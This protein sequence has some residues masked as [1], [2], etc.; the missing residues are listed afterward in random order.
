MLRQDQ[1]RAVHLNG[2]SSS[3][4]LDASSAV[5]VLHVARDGRIAGANAALARLVGAPE[6]AG[7]R[8]RPVSDI[9]A[10]GQD[11][12]V[13]LPSGERTMHRDVE[14][15][16]SRGHG[17]IAVLRGDV[18]TLD[19]GGSGPTACGV[20]SD[21]TELENLRHAM[22]HTARL[23][24]LASLTGGVAHDF[25]NLLTVLVGNLSL[26]AEEFRDQPRTFAR[27]KAARDAATRGSDLITQL[28]G[29]AGAEEVETSAID[30]SEVIRKVVP[31]VSSALGKR[32]QLKTE[33]DAGAGSIEANVA[34][35]E[36]V[37]VNLA[38]NARDA[39]SGHGTVTISSSRIRL[40]ERE[41][42]KRGLDPGDYIRVRVVDDG[43]GIERDLLERVF[44]PFFSTK[45]ERGGTGIGLSMVRSFARRLGG[46]AAIRS[47]VGKGTAVSLWLPVSAD[48][49]E[50]G[51]SAQTAALATLPSGTEHVVLLIADAGLGTTVRQILEVL[52][53]T[54]T[55]CVDTAELGAAASR[56]RLD[57]LIVD[58][59]PAGLPESLEIARRRHPEVRLLQLL[60]ASGAA[61]GSVGDGAAMLAKPFS[62]PDLASLVRDTLDR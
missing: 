10:P 62:L 38:V 53:Y 39:I 61:E 11:T 4:I 21:C 28:R 46:R 20:F 45:K 24:A 17:Q 1:P 32:I 57:L 59:A 33:L 30:P 36:S 3:A 27:L 58:G 44:D 34:Q 35:L 18:F 15:R 40:D 49:T 5:A 7:L 25:N 60:D 19:E 14:L 47:K 37:I 16:L 48:V 31:L 6:A 2:A 56:S 41:A 12:R 51:S 50:T 43:A 42:R 55:V 26:I 54:V 9:A 8:G 22:Q 13:L 29:F 52:G 23:E